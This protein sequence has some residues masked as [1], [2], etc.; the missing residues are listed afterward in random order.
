MAKSDKNNGEPARDGGPFQVIDHGT[1]DEM[2]VLKMIIL[3]QPLVRTLVMDRLR[4]AKTR[5]EK[6]GGLPKKAD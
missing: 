2:E 5:V 3:E 1:Q 4:Q 6:R